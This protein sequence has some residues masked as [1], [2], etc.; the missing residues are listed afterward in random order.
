MFVF[1]SNRST[2]LKRG[3]FFSWAANT[4]KTT[5]LK[6]KM[7]NQVI[8][9]NQLLGKTIS[10]CDTRT[11]RKL[12][13]GDLDRIKFII[14]RSNHYNQPREPSLSWGWLDQQHW[15]HD[16]IFLFGEASASTRNRICKD[17]IL[18][19]GWKVHHGIWHYE[20]ESYFV[21]VMGMAIWYI[22]DMCTMYMVNDIKR[23]N[24][25]WCLWW[26]WVHGRWPI[27]LSLSPAASLD[28]S[29]QLHSRLSHSWGWAII[30]QLWMDPNDQNY[31]DIYE[32]ISYGFISILALLSS[33]AVNHFC[34]WNS[35]NI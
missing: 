21:S 13:V 19:W 7:S 5:Y 33:F 17:L 4:G 9:V 1:L 28:G 18:H 27:P 23:G 2:N 34:I 8:C 31:K 12:W 16:P 24:L 14:D 20:G 11:L 32:K 10:Y 26:E 35:Y 6:K 25:T 29:S 15:H 22:G 30:K 3:N